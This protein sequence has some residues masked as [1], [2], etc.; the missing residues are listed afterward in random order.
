MAVNVVVPGAVSASTP[1][2]VI[3]GLDDTYKTLLAV[4]KDIAKEMD[5]TLRGVLTYIADVAK[6]RAPDG[7]TGRMQAGYKVKRGRVR[8]AGTVSWRAYNR[9]RQGAILEFAGSSSNG[10][11]GQGQSLIRNLT[12]KYGPTGRFLWQAYDE[13]ADFVLVSVARTAEKY[14]AALQ[15]RLDR[16]G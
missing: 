16:T 12:Q 6:G 7:D 15:A 14:E 9:T 11:T 13:N 2:V 3:E 5:K 1:Q 8:G 10:F 4:D